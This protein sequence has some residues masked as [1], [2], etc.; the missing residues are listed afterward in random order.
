MTSR[1]LTDEEIQDYLDGNLQS[2][3]RLSEEHL[4]TCQLCQNTM[5]E[6]NRLYEELKVDEG[7]ELSP[8]FLE[9]VLSRLKKEKASTS[10][11]SLAEIL[12]LG[13]MAVVALFTTIYFVNWASFGQVISRILLSEAETLLTIWGN[14]VK[15]LMELNLSPDLLFLAGVILLI[16][17]LLDYLIINRS[18]QLVKNHS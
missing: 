11:L 14:S 1:H 15:L 16:I 13:M 6:Y 3:N 9:S 12:I 2:E 10:S 5:E 7:F 18:N 4:Q 8:G 17:K